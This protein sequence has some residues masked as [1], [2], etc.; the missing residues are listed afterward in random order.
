MFG[1][2]KSMNR[3]WSFDDCF[4][5]GSILSATDPGIVT[6]FLYIKFR[7]NMNQ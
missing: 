4:L 7:Y 2:T 6:G 1:F 3:S 5:L